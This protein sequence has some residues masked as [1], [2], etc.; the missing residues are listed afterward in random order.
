MKRNDIRT[1]T[2]FEPEYPPILLETY[3]PPWV[4]YT[5]GN[6]SLLTKDHLL[7]VVGSRKAT[8]LW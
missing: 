4:L 8:T 3:K 1:I 5:K 2:I 6:P 7:A